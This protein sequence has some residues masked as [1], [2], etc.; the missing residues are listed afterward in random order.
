MVK[1]GQ[2]TREKAQGD[3]LF[4]RLLVKAD[5]GYH[6]DDDDDF[7][8]EDYE[9][10]GGPDKEKRLDLIK[11]GRMGRELFEKG[12]IK[13]WNGN[14][15]AD[16]TP[17][18]WFL[19]NVNRDCIAAAINTDL[20]LLTW[21][22]K[23]GA[24]L[25]FQDKD[26]NTAMHYAVMSCRDMDEHIE[27][28]RDD[29]GILFDEAKVESGDIALE[30]CLAHPEDAKGRK[31][32]EKEPE[33]MFG[34]KY[35]AGMDKWSFD[36]NSMIYKRIKGLQRPNADA[37]RNLDEKYAEWVETRHNQ[38]EAVQL[39]LLGEADVS[40][41]NKEGKTPM[42]LSA[43]KYPLISQLIGASAIC[44]AMLEEEEL[45]NYREESWSGYAGIYRSCCYN[46]KKPPGVPD[47]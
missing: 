23:S 6:P 21:C 2:I 9:T 39:L 20:E 7:K 46:P 30:K 8:W 12:S 25:S 44:A 45:L 32:P 38:I 27:I 24:N 36:K 31:H 4:G 11:H 10:T 37:R 43:G 17:F 3:F 1:E 13:N 22:I 19:K 47:I 26:G 14:S 29:L 35:N 40:L 34:Y 18:G 15:W 16:W 41:S 42:D 33:S 5:L 28:G